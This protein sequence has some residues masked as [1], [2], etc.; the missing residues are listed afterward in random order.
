MLSIQA[1]ESLIEIESAEAAGSLFETNAWVI[2]YLD[3]FILTAAMFAA[4]LSHSEGKSSIEEPPAAVE[5]SETH[6]PVNASAP[7]YTAYIPTIATDWQQSAVLALQRHRFTDSIDIGFEKGY[8][9]L[10][11]GSAVLFEV[12]KANLRDEGKSVIAELASYLKEIDGIIVIQGHTDSM[13][14]QSDEFPSNWELASARANNVLHHMVKLGVDRARLRAVS[15]ADTKPLAPNSNKE[16]RQKNRRVNIVL[17]SPD[18]DE[19][20]FS[21]PL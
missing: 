18:L 9:E 14:I 17:L 10:S 6:Y 1:E 3:I 16:N 19:L 21:P 8:A 15:F 2:S 7:E 13:P 5:T 12:S 11:I 20:S 4:L